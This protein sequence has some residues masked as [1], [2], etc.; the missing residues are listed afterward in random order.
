MSD[1]RSVDR[2]YDQTD[3][4]A[5][6]VNQESPAKPGNQ[7][8]LDAGNNN[9]CTMWTPWCDSQAEMNESH[10]IE[11]TIGPDDP[12]NRLQ[13]F[14]SGDYVWYTTQLDYSLRQHVQG[15]NA[16]GKGEYNMYIQSDRTIRY[17]KF[18]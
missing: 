15:D 2:I 7:L 14:Q 10:Y 13:I 16:S 5:K 3:Q 18:A 6:I 17:E 12:A 4:T 1:V 11:V 8:V 9:T